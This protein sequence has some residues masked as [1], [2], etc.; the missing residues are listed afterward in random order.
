MALYP[1]VMRKAQEEIDN[2]TGSERLPCFAD[3]PNLPYV[4]AL[5]LE[6]FR[7][8]SV[9]PT[10]TSNLLGYVFDGS[11]IASSLTL[12][13]AHRVMEDNIY[14]GYLIPKGSL[15]IPNVW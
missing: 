2:V 15:V 6:V 10:G 12:A 4:N 13:I 14:D 9:V 8:H 1:E 7:W 3:R 5:H 11:L